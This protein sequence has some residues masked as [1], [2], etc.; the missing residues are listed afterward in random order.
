MI[1]NMKSSGG[2]G[3]ARASAVDWL[4]AVACGMM[5]VMLAVF[6]AFNTDASSTPNLWRY[7]YL[8]L[9]F[10]GGLVAAIAYFTLS[11]WHRRL[12]VFNALVLYGVVTNLVLVE[13][14]FRLFPAL[15]PPQV[16][17]LL[18]EDTRQQIAAERGLFT[19]NTFRG[20]GMLYSYN[21]AAHPFA[22]EY[23][24]IRLDADGFRNP[25]IPKGHVDLV[26]FGDS[27]TFARHAKADFGDVLRQ[28]GVNAYS[29]AM[30]G[31]ST[32]HYRDAYYKYVLGRHLKHDKVVVL[33]SPT[34]DLY[35]ATKYA[36]VA[37]SNGDYRDYLGVMNTIG[38][39]WPD[40]QPFLTV[41]ALARLPAL[42]R[43]TLTETS[44]LLSASLKQE[45]K[46]ELPYGTY[47]VTPQ[48]LDF[49]KVDKDGDLWRKFSQ[50]LD[51]IVAGA[52]QYKAQVTFVVLP[53]PPLLFRHYIHGFA[54]F[55][56]VLDQRYRHFLD[57]LA[58][59]YE[60]RG[61]R[62]IDLTEY[63][64]SEIGKRPLAASPLGYHFNSDGWIYLSKGLIAQAGF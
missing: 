55:K 44:A 16:V 62:I 40:S 38:P 57:L 49:P 11:L 8:K 47:S 21:T 14:T 30:G 58:E 48:F 60:V 64:A 53:G 6:F 2:A 50:P 19:N 63:M 54:H 10:L 27:V 56:E 28:R 37:E 61:V 22:K 17:P 32:P 35:E 25:E 34:T 36:K 39:T 1:E 5:A 41:A 59:R 51:D 26:Y 23:P 24:W 9:L 7:S 45:E 18:P 31:N 43:K 12:R 4:S 20:D 29:L 46:V 52:K 33:L 15:I 13:A 3:L 42:L